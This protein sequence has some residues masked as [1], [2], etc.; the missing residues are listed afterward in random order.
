M[1]ILAAA[2]AA[3]AFFATPAPVDMPR[4][5]SYLVTSAS[6]EKYIEDRYSEIDLWTAKTATGQWFDDAGRVFFLARIASAP[7]SEP[8]SFVTRS[9]AGRN[10][11]PLE[12]R[13][14]RKDD[15]VLARA[16]YLLSPVETVPE[17]VRPRRVPHGMRDVLY[18]Q[19]AN[20]SAV[21][22]TFLPEDGDSWHFASW[23][24]AE[25]D[26]F[27][28]ALEKFEED[29][30]RRWSDILDENPAAGGTDAGDPP[31][32]AGKKNSRAPAR[33][34]ARKSRRSDPL[35]A[36]KEFLRQAVRHRVAAYEGWNV[37]DAEDF[38]IVD[39]LAG[40]RAA[41]DAITNSLDSIRA[42]YAATI[43][44]PVAVTNVL[45]VV[46]IFRDRAEY[47]DVEGVN[48]HEGREWTA[49]YWSP[50]I[51][52]IVA[53]LPPGD[54]NALVQTFRHEAFHRYLSYAAA[55]AT[56]SPW[57]NEGYAGYF[58][59]PEDGS[60]PEGVDIEAAA[61]FLPALMLMDY[62]G[63]YD[64]SGPVDRA[65]KYAL[66]RSIA[67]F[68]ENGADKVRDKPFENLKKDYMDALVATRDPQKAMSAA[69]KSEDGLKLFA[70][71]W[72]KFWQKR[73]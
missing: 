50:Q 52:E 59:D 39:D 62:E 33:V 37:S 16:V 40:E 43:P 2:A 30:L 13:F 25:G 6:G 7:P 45:S 23:T 41:V 55:F 28:K 9:A 65:R 60:F 19:G 58:E 73:M 4:A 15:A 5:E 69:F 51:R 71:E 44:A 67:F 38:C 24:L 34:S 63:F 42:L 12:A 18:W 66:A 48:G 27:G 8:Y 46:R 35:A 53:Y 11:T 57:F 31:R 14:M 29:F 20:E 47:L 17:G 56:A 22:C 26:A 68:I 54:T 1:T 32:K 70:L 61:G 21:V 49:A 3:A 36:E 64:D 10:E 72:K